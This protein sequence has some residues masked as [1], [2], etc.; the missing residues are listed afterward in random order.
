MIKRYIGIILL[1]MSFSAVAGNTSKKTQYFLIDTIEF[2]QGTNL[3]QESVDKIIQ[4]IKSAKHT[5][6]YTYEPSSKTLTQFEEALPESQ[7]LSDEND[8]IIFSDQT[9]KLDSLSSEGIVLSSTIDEPFLKALMTINL[10]RVEQSNP[11]LIT[12]IAKQDSIYTKKINFITKQQAV[13]DKV[14]ISDFNGY[15]KMNRFGAIKLPMN[16]YLDKML[17]G[18]FLIGI[19]QLYADIE[20]KNV[21]IFKIKGENDKQSN[22]DL[23]FLVY[24]NKKAEDFNLDRHLAS[25]KIPQGILYREKKVNALSTTY[26]INNSY[27]KERKYL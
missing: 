23:G 5:I 17:S 18:I 2:E 26:S 10:V 11:S 3:Y 6:Y 13:L 20:D 22:P 25:M 12:I 7:V 19:D 21:T 1:L 9:F 14:G 4:S 8:E 24:A 27:H 15:N 16:T